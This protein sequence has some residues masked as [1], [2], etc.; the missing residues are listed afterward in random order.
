MYKRQRLKGWLEPER[1]RL[2]ALRLLQSDATIWDRNG[3]DAAFL[4]HRD[5]RMAEAV[6]L[7]AIERYRKHLG[8][9]DDDYLVAC[10]EAERLARWRM[11]RQRTLIYALSGALIGAF[12]GVTGSALI[13]DYLRGVASWFTTIRIVP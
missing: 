7:A 5:K 2:E 12:A 13:G 9:V 11:R 8:A 4:N 10:R 3:R 1:A 6:A